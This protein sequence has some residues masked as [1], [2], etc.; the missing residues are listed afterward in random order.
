VFLGTS[1]R[2]EKPAGKKLSDPAPLSSVTDTEV[3]AA[4]QDGARGVAEAYLKAISGEGEEAA[5][6][7]LLGGVTLTA[8]IF[9]LENWKIVGR[10]KHRTEV[11]ELAHLHASVDGLERAGRETLNKFLSESG[12]GAVS[13][14]LGVLEVSTEQAKQITGPTRD[15]AAKFTRDH[16]VF[17]YIARVDKALYWHS[18][19]PFRK[20]L[21]DAGAK[22]KYTADLDLFWIESAEGF[23][24]DRTVRKWPLRVVRF[25]AGEKDTGLRVLPASD[26]DGD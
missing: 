11:G 20:L 25:R 6:G 3:A 14:E 13:D 23:S 12:G 18:K 26:W 2:A 19:N 4:E 15:R 16:P 9:R 7:T 22:G 10:Q 8:K 1:A 21:T 17:A 5:L 24:K